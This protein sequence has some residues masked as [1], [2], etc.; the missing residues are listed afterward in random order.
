MIAAGSA[1]IG[2]TASFSPFFLSF[3]KAFS[4]FSLFLPLLMILKMSLFLYFSSL[5]FSP[6]YCSLFLLFLYY[7]SPTIL[8]L[9]PYHV[10]LINHPP[11]PHPR[12]CPFCHLHPH[13]SSPG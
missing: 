10:N 3:S 2:P 11:P 1:C 7:S 9:T 12:N 6:L 4:F 8:H 13:H 5:C